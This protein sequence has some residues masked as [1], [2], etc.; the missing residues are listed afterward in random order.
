MFDNYISK[1]DSERF[2]FPVAKF[3]NNID[4]L[5]LIVHELKKA[6]IGLIIAR[7]DLK[8]IN[9]ISQLE[10]LGFRYKDSQ[11]TFSFDIQKGLPKHA[12]NDFF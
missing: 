7:V 1:L 9:L 8:D 2:G 4:K 3:F 6:S 11:V 5:E 12:Q 10:K